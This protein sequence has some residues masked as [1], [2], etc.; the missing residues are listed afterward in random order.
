MFKLASPLTFCVLFPVSTLLNSAFSHWILQFLCPLNKRN[1][2]YLLSS[3]CLCNYKP[4]S[5]HP[6]NL[7]VDKTL[8]W[9]KKLSHCMF[10]SLH[11]CSLFFLT[12]MKKIQHWTQQ[13][14]SAGNNSPCLIFQLI[15]LKIILVHTWNSI[16]LGYSALLLIRKFKSF[17]LE[18]TGQRGNRI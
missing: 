2:K 5:S 18:F 7:P 16:I 15:Y 6:F 10:S 8:D 17:N 12:K 14:S 3:S 13:Q 11:L 9:L 1:S 4:R